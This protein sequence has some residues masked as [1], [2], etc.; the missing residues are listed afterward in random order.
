MNYIYCLSL[1]SLFTYS[2]CSDVEINNPK[3]KLVHAIVDENGKPSRALLELLSQAHMDHDGTLETIFAKT[4]EVWLRS[5]GKE[6]WENQKEFAVSYT[7]L[8]PLFEELYLTQTVEPANQRYD[9]AVFLGA[10]VN[11]VRNRLA[12]LI[13]SWQK[14]TRF[15]SIVILAGARPLDK[16]IESDELLLDTIFTGLPAKQDWQFNGQFPT[17]ETEM[18]RFVFDQTQ[19]PQAWNKEVPIIFVD[20]PLQKTDDGSLRRPNTQDTIDQWLHDHKPAQGSILALSHQPYVGYQD[21]VLRRSLA[22]RF[23]IE[24]VG[25]GFCGKDESIPNIFDSLA[26]WIYNEYQMTQSR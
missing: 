15:N 17:T 8:S 20:T 14:G 1:L 12:F 13:E 21:V 11:S 4:Q 16:K 22:K 25:K 19:L 10:T 7:T 26:R 3:N 6:R 5:A 23:S 24:T 9:Y 2:Y 18:I